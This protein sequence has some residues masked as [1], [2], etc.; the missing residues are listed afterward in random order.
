MEAATLAGAVSGKIGKPTMEAA[1]PAPD[2]EP[3]DALVK[4]SFLNYETTKRYGENGSAGRILFGSR[5]TL[6]TLR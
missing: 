3:N 1:P 6:V 5:R 4:E 2:T